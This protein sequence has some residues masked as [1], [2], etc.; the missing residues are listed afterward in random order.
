[1]YD[2][3][4][5]TL[6]AP[7]MR[8]SVLP[9]IEPFTRLIPVDRLDTEGLE[10]LAGLANCTEEASF[11]RAAMGLLEHLCEL[12]LFRRLSKT[13]QDDRTRATYRNLI[14]L[15]TISVS[16]RR[17]RTR[18]EPRAPQ[19]VRAE[20]SVGL[21]GWNLPGHYL[22][23]LA[24]ATRP[25]DLSRAVGRLYEL[26]KKSIDCERSSI[27]L[28]QAL[29]SSGSGSLV[30]LEELCVPREGEAFAPLELREEVEKRGETIA[31]PDLAREASLVRSM[32]GESRGAL[33]VA[34]LKTEG[35]VYGTLAVWSSTPHAFDPNAVG[36][37]GFV[38]E[39]AAG[40]LKGRLELEE[41][42]FVD[43][44]SQIHNR[45]YF[46]E[47]LSREI[48]RSERTGDAMALLI[49]D[50][51]DFKTVNDTLGHAAGD[52]V[53]RQVARILSDNARQVDI[54]ARYGG[55]EFGLILP[56]ISR[57]SAL[58]VAERIR[59][60]VEMHSF[61]TGSQTRPT[62]DLTVSIGAALYPTDASTKM[63]LVDRADRIALYEAKRR[64]KNRVVVYSH[65][66]D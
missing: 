54:V 14:T 41:L 43:P 50:I 63:E 46:D 35:Y 40:L 58:A 23:D 31:I 44:T 7:T 62:W 10:L 24:V 42:I 45:R 34:P 15:D 21:P 56:N 65:Q 8:K 32:D 49:A 12:G 1:M 3:V 25:D 5:E 13:V 29:A 36:F 2:N 53:L 9:S 30:E 33:V 59:K 64:G 19:A 27:C 28:T 20:E 17:D 52:S 11:S 18:A 4:S 66:K 60:T 6:S 48:E 55:E 26:L 51:D 16:A 37:V 38:A 61:I 22:H 39:F 47:Q 57:E